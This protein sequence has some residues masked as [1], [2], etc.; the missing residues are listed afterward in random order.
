MLARRPGVT[1]ELEPLPFLPAR[2]QAIAA[3]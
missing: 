2:R 3:E 1:V